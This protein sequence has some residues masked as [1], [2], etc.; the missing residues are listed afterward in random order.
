M[1]AISYDGFEGYIIIEGGC[2]QSVFNYFIDSI[3]KKYRL[4]NDED[5][6]YFICDN[7][8]IH[9]NSTLRTTIGKKIN[10]VYLPP[11]TPVF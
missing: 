11:H 4:E 7:A 2:T 1:V 8:I 9:H 5:R 6:L 10:I 3:V